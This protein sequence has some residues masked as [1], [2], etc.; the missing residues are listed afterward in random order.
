MRGVKAKRLRRQSYGEGN[1]MPRGQHHTYR[2]MSTG[3]SFSFGGI[4]QGINRLNNKKQLIY[5]RYQ[6]GMLLITSA[7]RLY[8]NL[9]KGIPVHIFREGVTA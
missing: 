5:P 6:L 8:K 4:K 9:K 1:A 3:K 7:R 2:D